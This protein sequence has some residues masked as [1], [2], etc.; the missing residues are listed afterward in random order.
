VAIVKGFVSLISVSGHLSFVYRRA[1]DFH[2]NFA[3]C[4]FAKSANR[5]FLVEF[6]GSFMYKII[7]FTS[8]HTLIS[9]L[10]FRFPLTS[11]SC[12]ITLAKNSSSI[13]KFWREQTTLS[14]S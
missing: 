1:T 2:V 8:K 10:P 6:L 12:L 11:F 13:R 4:Y 3:S 14:C 9:S 7:L 5:L